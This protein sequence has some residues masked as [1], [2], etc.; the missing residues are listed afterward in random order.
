MEY[1]RFDFSSNEVDSGGANEGCDEFRSWFAINLH[2]CAD[3]LQFSIIEYR[4]AIS[5]R[6]RFNLIVR[7][8]D[9]SHSKLTLQL[10]DV[11]PHLSP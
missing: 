2:R 11:H 1:P 5:D 7:N 10:A 4:Q 6:H 8:E 9:R 3:L